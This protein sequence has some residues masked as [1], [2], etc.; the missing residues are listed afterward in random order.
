MQVVIFGSSIDHEMK[1]KIQFQKLK[2]AFRKHLMINGRSCIYR[3][4]VIFRFVFEKIAIRS[5]MKTKIGRKQTFLQK[6]FLQ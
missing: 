2:L 5:S 1:S 6:A 3:C 4:V